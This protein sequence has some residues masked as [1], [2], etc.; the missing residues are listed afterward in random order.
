MAPLH[1]LVVEDNTVNQRVL[2]LQ[3]ERAGHSVH[4]VGNGQEALE[5]LAR[6]QFDLVLMDLQMPQMDGVR[7]TRLIRAR[8]KAFGG[9]IAIIAVT[10]NSLPQE[11][12][13]SLAAGMDDYLVKPIRAA[14][15][16]AAIARVKGTATPLADAS[17]TPS[18]EGWQGAL[19]AMG[20][21]PPAQARLAQAFLGEVP[22]RM[23]RLRQA[24]QT[25]D[26]VGVQMM[27]HALKGTLTVFSVQSAVAAA[28]TLEEL[29]RR[30]EL[31][32]AA[33][34]LAALEGEVERLLGEL[35]AFLQGTS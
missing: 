32:E 7:T 2:S 14:E 20:F 30:Q 6:E 35:T 10:A 12:Q 26:T 13:R 3:L 8:E 11:R 18:A 1:V 17:G 25:G 15:L 34:P 27:A 19:Q 24:L 29:G 16:Y 21:S 28:A 22:G 5:V 33:G 9:H 4:V 31:S 23:E